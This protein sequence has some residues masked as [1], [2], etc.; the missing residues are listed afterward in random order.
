VRALQRIAPVLW[1]STHIL[2][3]TDIPTQ[4]WDY[5]WNRCKLAYLENRPTWKQGPFPENYQQYALNWQPRS[6]RYLQ[7]F[8]RPTPFRTRLSEMVKKY[9]GYWSDYH[10]GIVLPPNQG[11]DTH[12]YSALPR[13]E[14]LDSTYISCQVESTS[15][16][17]YGIAFTEKTYDHLI[18]G[19]LTLNFGPAGF[20]R[21]L[22]QDGWQ[23]YQGIDISWDQIVNNELR[24][25]AYLGCLETL[26]KL[27]DADMHD[28]FLL[29]KDVI[30]H[31][32][33]RLREKPYD[34]FD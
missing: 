16:S 14:F 18:Q 15:E 20:Y 28:L 2:S 9:S 10:Q 31:N 29:N 3:V 33:N 7:L 11:H 13:R 34:Y 25:Q 12:W 27:S 1:V 26:F 5:L 17:G 19:R 8:N 6:K 4:R 23:L 24:F 30:I 21:A 32:Y 22:R